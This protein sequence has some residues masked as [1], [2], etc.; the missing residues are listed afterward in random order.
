M[1]ILVGVE[2]FGKIEKADI[3]ISNYTVFVGDNNSG[4]TYLMQLIYG[5]LQYFS[6]PNDY[7]P[8]RVNGI[9]ERVKNSIDRV[10]ISPREMET[11]CAEINDYLSSEKESLVRTIFQRDIPIG[12]LYIMCLLDDGMLEV[13]HEITKMS[14]GNGVEPHAVEIWKITYK[15]EE[16]GAFYSSAEEVT[17]ADILN[18]FLFSMGITR[19]FRLFMPASRTGIQL[20]YKEF[21]AQT[22][23]NI[24][25]QEDDKNHFGLTRPVYDFLRFLQTYK[26]IEENNRNPILEFVEENLIAGHL[27][28]SN[29]DNIEYIPQGDTVRVPL[30]LA[31]SMINELAPIVMMLTSGKFYEQL[32]IDEVETSLHPKKQKEMMRLLSRINN[33]GTR[34]IISTHSDTM[35]SYLNLIAIL[36]RNRQYIKR[37]L[38]EFGLEESDIL[39]SGCIHFYQ[40]VENNGKSFVEELLFTDAPA[41]GVDFRLFDESLDQLYELSRSVMGV[42]D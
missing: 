6:F 1:R 13:S 29:N 4:K 31:S 17:A 8:H 40:F 10:E 24:F 37:N 23:D 20:L 22:V 16:K 19:N 39:L 42:E 21:Y 25:L 14:I 2:N 5:L 15:G 33:R 41:I 28:A 30:Y 27:R 32:F 12:K 38:N 9:L 36:S 34:L 11:V 3:D 18:M 7:K 35:A 26:A